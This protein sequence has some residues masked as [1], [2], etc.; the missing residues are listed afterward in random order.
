MEEKVGKNLELF[1]RG[2]NFQSITPMSHALRPRIDKWD[3]I[4][5]ESFCKAKDIVNRT[6]RKP[7]DW[8]KIFTNP[9]SDRGLISKIYK[10]LKKLIT[11]KTK[12]PNQK[13]GIE[14]NLEFT[15]EES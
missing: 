5:L 13:W 10:E 2:G 15:T 11:K 3:L 1:G 14:L 6:N 12:Q 9:T 8:E 7:T 4:K